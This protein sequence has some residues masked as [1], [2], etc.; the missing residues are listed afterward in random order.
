MLR[1]KH[2]IFF[3]P[4]GTAK[5]KGQIYGAPRFT[6]LFNKPVIYHGV[7]GQG[8]FQSHLPRAAVRL[9]AYL[10]S[11]EW[12][13]LTAFHRRARRAAGEAAHRAATSCSS[14]RSS[15]RSPT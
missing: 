13:V 3:G 14:A 12:V 10:S 8:L 4:T 15:S 9:A 5:W 1:F 11:I 2:L 6:W 7:F